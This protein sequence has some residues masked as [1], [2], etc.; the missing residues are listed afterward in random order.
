VNKYKFS[1]VEQNNSNT[2]NLSQPKGDGFPDIKKIVFM[3]L[4]NWY[5]FVISIPICLASVFIYHRY[6]QDIY[7]G[8]VTIMIKSDEAKTISRAELIE[9]FGLSPEMKSIE[10]QTI[11]LRS[12]KIVKRAIDKLDFAIDIYSDGVM[13]DYDMY[14]KSPFSVRMDSSHV[15]LLNTAIHIQPLEQNKVNITIETEGAALHTFKSEQNSGTSGHISFSKNFNWGDEIET[16]YCKFRLEPKYQGIR[17]GVNYYFYFRSHNWLASSYRNRIGV[18]PYKEGS[19]ILYISTTGTNTE[20]ITHFLNALS[21]VYLEQSLERKNEIATRTISFIDIQ[22]KQ[23]SDSLKAAQ[24]KLSHFR[25]SNLYSAPSEMSTRLTDQYFEYQ[26]QLK[27][28]DIKENY[29]KNL[30]KHLKENP[31]SEDYLM[32]AF[33]Q[34][35][36]GFISTLVSELLTLSNERAMLSSQ[37]STINPALEDL[38]RKLDISKKNLILSLDK[39][40]KNVKIEKDKLLSD[41]GELSGKMNH[42]PELERKY[43]DIEREYKLNDAIYT[44]L[45]QKQ[46]ETQISKASNTPDNEIIDEAVITGIVSPNKS[47]NNRQALMLALV[48]PVAIIILKEYLNNKIRSKEDI[49]AIASG[50]P[51]IGYIPQYKGPHNNVIQKEPISNISESFRALRIKLKF[52]CPANKKSIITV[53]STNTGEGKTFC[54]LNLAS[55][56]AISGKKT[57]LVGFD[58]RKPRLTE[59]FSHYNNDG[60]SHYLIGQTKLDDIIYPGELENLKIIPSGAIPPNPSELIANDYTKQL[61]T[62]LQEKF[63]V[64]IVD[65]PPIGVV[66]DAR[67]L[68]DYSFCHLFVV[69]AEHTIKE[70]FKHTIQN[71]M[72]ENIENI[73]FIYNDISN[74]LGNYHYYTDKYYEE[75]KNKK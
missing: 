7:R 47:K 2:S 44:F 35:A 34:D 3:V 65:S 42:L 66:A 68:M 51:I 71:L 63:D 46:S 52:M 15:Q 41:M 4:S 49:Y 50:L 13:K 20:K 1:S 74:S 72:S 6:I 59:I 39:L 40:L 30:S 27:F 12:K 8:S 73:G 56:Y 64:I 29:Y 14:H 9:G 18:S 75:S 33:S 24:E 11:I 10:N 43:L 22:L 70:H 5:L 60:L 26:K 55:A 67:I 53:T 37:S 38:E 48:I 36:N 19:S 17:E 54:A 16:P 45:L 58:L 31:L 62:E 28:L 69:R 61:F 32:P 21:K 25:R 23:V 57:V